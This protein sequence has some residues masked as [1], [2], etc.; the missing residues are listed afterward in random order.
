MEE[1]RRLPFSI[2]HTLSRKSPMLDESEIGRKIKQLRQERGLSLQGLAD[3]VGFTKGYLSK[4]E[5]SRKSPP[6]STLVTLATAL[7]VSVAALLSEEETKTSITL[8][9]KSE[10]KTMALDAT[11][12]GYSYEPLASKFPNR[13]ME[14]HI[15]TLP[16]KRKAQAVFQ[17][18]G[19]E[20]LFVLEGAMRFT[21]GDTQFLLEEGDCIYF[22]ASVPHFG[23]V[24]GSKQVKCLMVIC[25]EP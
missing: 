20:L 16:V 14:P 7:G 22:D 3:E 9:K 17:H 8:V 15:L 4:V 1:T 24:E 6:V 19:Q 10:R 13:L 18:K 25:R 2:A 5:N 21:H 23:K 12:F 11:A